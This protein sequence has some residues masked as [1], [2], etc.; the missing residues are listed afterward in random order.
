[1]HGQPDTP[2]ERDG[3]FVGASTD[4][5]VESNTGKHLMLNLI[6]DTDGYH[7]SFN[8]VIKGN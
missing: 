3:I 2:N 5:L 6:N 1:L 7:G 4:G 8:V